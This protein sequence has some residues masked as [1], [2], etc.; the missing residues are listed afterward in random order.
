MLLSWLVIPPAPA[1]HLTDPMF[2]LQKCIK[3]SSL[4]GECIGSIEGKKDLCSLEIIV[5]SDMEEFKRYYRKLAEDKEW[6]GTFGFTEAR[7]SGPTIL[8]A[9]SFKVA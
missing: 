3:D 6:Q 7:A 1:N 2:G 5:G 8:E 4:N 9:S